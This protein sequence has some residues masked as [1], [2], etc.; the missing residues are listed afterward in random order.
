MS[1]EDKS[2]KDG[3]IPLLSEVSEEFGR[4]FSFL[5]KGDTTPTTRKN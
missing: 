3:K 2:A 4:D 5:W 1:P